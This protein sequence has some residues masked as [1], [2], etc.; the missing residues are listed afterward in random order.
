MRLAGGEAAEQE[1]GASGEGGKKA[2]TRGSGARGRRSASRAKRSGKKN[3]AANGANLGFENKLWEM[4]DKMRGHMDALLP[5][6]SP[7]SLRVPDA[8]KVLE[9]VG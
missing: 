3:G 5:S 6:S 9:S 8:E 1:P 7:A 4:A 2:G